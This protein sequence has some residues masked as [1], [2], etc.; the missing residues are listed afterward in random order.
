MTDFDYI[1]V[2]AGSAG[3]VLANR[4]SKDPGNRVLLIEAGGKDTNPLIRVPK[5]FGKM[6]ANPKLAWQYPVRPIGP[7]Q[8]VEQ[9]ARGR[10]LGGSS[11]INGMVYNRGSAADYDGIVEL[12]N[13]GWGWSEILPIFRMIENHQL[14]ANDMRGADG[15]PPARL[16]RRSARGRRRRR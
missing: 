5:G 1:V 14:G 11:A 8:K 2:G 6:L 12:G 4:L 16:P 7:S 3:C 15:P 9:W 10:V 13:P